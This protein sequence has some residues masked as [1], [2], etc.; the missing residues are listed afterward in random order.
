[1]PTKKRVE[2]QQ[3]F[4]GKWVNPNCEVD[5]ILKENG[6]CLEIRPDGS[7]VAK[8]VWRVTGKGT[9]MA[10]LS[11]DRRDQS[12]AAVPRLAYCRAAAWRYR[13]KSAWAR[14]SSSTPS[15]RSA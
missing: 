15:R 8:G 7:M 5:L 4:V 9:A 2:Y 13:S 10:A 12:P 3:R 1:M 11:N 14:A 6:E